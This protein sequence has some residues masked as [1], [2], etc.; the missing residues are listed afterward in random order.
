LNR[1]IKLVKAL[2]SAWLMREV[3]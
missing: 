2:Q 3:I 1:L